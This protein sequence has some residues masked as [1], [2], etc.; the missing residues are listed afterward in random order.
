[1]DFL[2]DKKYLILVLFINFI[3]L[4]VSQIQ[5]QSEVMAWGNITGV[6]VDGQLMEFESSLRLVSPCWSE[7]TVTGKEKQQPLFDRE[8]NIQTIKTGFGGQSG[9]RSRTEPQISFIQTVED[10]SKNTISVKL[11][12]EVSVDTL[13]QGIYFCIDLPA[14]YYSNGTLKFLNASPAGKAVLP[15]INLKPEEN[16]DPFKV[17]AK[18]ISVDSPLRNIEISIHS[19][20]KIFVRKETENFQIYIE[21]LGSKLKKGDSSGR[22]ITLTAGGEIDHNPVE[23]EIDSKNPGRRFDGIGGNFRLQN[24]RTDP[25]VIDYC[26]DNLRV[27]WGRVE[28]PWNLWHPEEE[29]N[30]VDAAESGNLNPRVKTAME[31]A[32]RLAAMDMPVI[33]SD[34]SAPNWAILGDPR[35]AY[36]NRSKGI[37][38][39]QLN[40]EKTQKIYQSIGDYIQYMKD[41]FGVEAAMFSFNESDLGINVR[42]T[43]EEHAEFIKGLGKHLAS[44]GLSTKLLLGDNSDATTFDFIFP[45]M[46]DPET[47]KYIGAISFHS[48]RGCTDEILKKWADASI[49]M[50]LPLIVGEGSTDAAAWNY[51]EIFSE[52]SFAL[53]EINLYTRICSICQPLS[54]LQW[55]LTAD[56]SILTGNGVFGIEGPLVP[57]QRFWNLR[58][59][60]STPVGSFSLPVT[61]DNKKVNCAAFS[62][63]AKGQYAIHLVNNGA[64]SPAIIKG[65]PDNVSVFE[66]FVTNS[67]QGMKKKGEVEVN[68][69]TVQFTLEQAG[70]TTLICK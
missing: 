37:F 52:Q 27:A 39:Y 68:E 38:G 6:R 62:N 3:L 7:I 42:H 57:T 40:P 1:M 60:A 51:P 50:N 61:C 31:M 19:K 46:N 43:G 55:Q 2:F 48:W 16:K 66:V 29:V 13:I 56:Y 35:D 53:N 12:T 65:I 34:W 8:G 5:A 21:L 15:L 32:Q 14:K 10:I 36:L 49:K 18:A 45:A 41:Y 25:A 69:G 30:P 26:L 33:I 23:L 9:F 64:S 59:L 28:M 4:P 22:E 11:K 70:F 67:E 24:P 17:S 54:I 44:R 47:H 58:Q 63:I 20:T